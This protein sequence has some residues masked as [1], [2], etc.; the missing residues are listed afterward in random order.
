MR[1]GF[2]V[3]RLRERLAALN[4]LQ[5]SKMRTWRPVRLNAFVIQQQ[6]KL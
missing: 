5:I 6:M 4:A 1:F 2:D 3:E